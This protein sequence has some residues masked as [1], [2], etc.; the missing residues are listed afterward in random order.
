MNEG[1]QRGHEVDKVQVKKLLENWP[2]NLNDFADKCKQ[3]NGG[4]STLSIE[5]QNYIYKKISGIKRGVSPETWEKILLYALSYTPEAIRLRLGWSIDWDETKPA[6][7]LSRMEE[8]GKRPVRL[9]RS[10]G[11]DILG[12]DNPLINKDFDWENETVQF[13]RKWDGSKKTLLEFGQKIASQ[14]G[15]SKEMIRMLTPQ[16]VSA[17]ILTYHF[18]AAGPDNTHPHS[19]GAHSSN[20]KR[21]ILQLFPTLAALAWA[22]RDI[23]TNFM[24]KIRRTR[25]N[26][27]EAALLTIPESFEEFKGLHFLPGTPQNQMREEYLTGGH[28]QAPSSGIPLEELYNNMLLMNSLY[29]RAKEAASEDVPDKIAVLGCV[30][31]RV[32][33]SISGKQIRPSQLEEHA[34]DA[35]YLTIGRKARGLMDYRL[36]PPFCYRGS[37]LPGVEHINSD[38][39]NM[40]KSHLFYQVPL[41]LEQVMSASFDKKFVYIDMVI[42]SDKGN[43]KEERDIFRGILFELREKLASLN[44]DISIKW[45]ILEETSEVLERGELEIAH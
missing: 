10:A 12:L 32:K 15:Y 8:G 35:F 29:P 14:L 11:S 44:K 24:I 3:E 16:D 36:G 31:D 27:S 45:R 26:D 28:E 38:I 6:K 37:I 21:A 30:D 7:L 5:E 43:A 41:I 4:I 40:L 39:A 42:S 18:E 13:T 19:C 34:S 25:K 33:N 1:G 17:Y 23:D 22:Y 2:K 9:F 20:T